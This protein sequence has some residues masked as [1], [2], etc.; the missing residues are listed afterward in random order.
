MTI[1]VTGAA[2]G[3]GLSTT[4]LLLKLGHSVAALDLQTDKMANYDASKFIRINCD[5]TNRE[6]IEKSFNTII[7]KFPTLDGVVNCAG[8]ATVGL[9]V[10]SKKNFEAN[11]QEFLRV[12]KINVIGTFLVSKVYVDLCL[13]NKWGKGVIVN[14]SSIAS[15]EGQN[16]QIIYAATKGAINSMTLPLARELGKYNIRVVTVMPGPI[17]T[18]MVKALPKKALDTLVSNS[19]LGKIGDPQNF[20]SFVHEILVNDYLNGGNLRL[21]GGIRAPKL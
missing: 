7:Q 2:S 11:E 15:T 13:A 3:L 12:F 14:V 9:M 10:S 8:V 21:D 16:G 20:A 4:E 18:D 6:S 5:V 19:L 17:M 1:V